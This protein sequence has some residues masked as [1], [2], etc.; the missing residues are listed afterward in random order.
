MDRSWE[1]HNRA[2][3]KL[4]DAVLFLFTAV[5]TALA[6]LRVPHFFGQPAVA[7]LTEIGVILGTLAFVCSC[8]LVFRR[9]PLAYL[10]GVVAGLITLPWFIWIELSLYE[11]S[12]ISFNSVSDSPEME[13]FLAFVKL[14]ILSTAL[15][16]ISIL[17]ASL[18]LLPSQW[19]LRKTPVNSR[20]WPAFAG[21]L[22][23]VTVW[24]LHSVT[25]YRTSV[26]TDGVTPD[27]RILHV[28]KR[29]LHIH[30]TG[31]SASRNGSLEVH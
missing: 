19:M 2:G 22:C 27:F 9:P 18:R 11:N 25:P 6:F 21:A 16:L 5:S 7:T 24:F 17:C 4:T 23:V 29:G 28:E 20:T 8:V 13:P 30:E 3:P 14:K 10:L 1:T 15:V 31:L 26:I 12:W